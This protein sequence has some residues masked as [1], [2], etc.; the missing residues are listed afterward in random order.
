MGELLSEKTSLT[1]EVLA[2]FEEKGITS[3]SVF[4]FGIEMGNDGS[5]HFPYRDGTK[6][7]QGIP[8]GT[9]SF[10]WE[11]GVPP[12]LFNLRDSLKKNLFLV[13]GETDTMKLRQELGDN[14]DTGVIG[15]PG[16]ETWDD[17]MA[18][19]L[20]QAE[21]I[22]V[23]LD[24][25][26]DYK[27]AGRVD[28][29]WTQIRL[30]LGKRARR[31]HLPNQINDVCEFF[32]TY[33]L[34]DLRTIVDR[35]PSPG[36]SRF[37]VLDLTADPPP[38]RWI[39]EDMICGGD[40]HM[41]IGEPSIGK[42]WITMGMA[43]AVAGNAPTFLQR[44]VLTH[45]RVL[46]IDEESPQDLIYHRLHRLGLNPEIAKN[47]RYLSNE[48]IRL[49]KQ[50]D[51]IVTEALDYDPELI[52]LDSL[53]RFHTEDENN[54]GAMATLFNDALKPLARKTGAAVVLIH[55]ANKT[56]SNSS[57]KRSRGS[58]DITAG[59]DCGYDVR[60]I[61]ERTV[62]VSNYKSRRAAQSDTFFVTIQDVE[63]RVELI[64]GDTQYIPF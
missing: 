45:G 36:E 25:D 49:D 22:W 60:A 21:Q 7:R 48:N 35:V 46:Y 37:T 40:I 17:R 39:I 18:E 53:T 29:A 59:A 28:H 52:I 50:A 33:G 19:D 26:G 5:I 12:C 64:G 62:A 56:D 6:K 14:P 10:R 15:L 13:E 1:P 23:I 11:Q 34:D 38:V 44:D 4:D 8:S 63:D 32:E 24:N 2:W 47:I 31:V 58:G 51:D 43:I 54:A 61:A 27:V 42:S 41:L 55:H 57:Y 30:A 20:T 3:E 9:R 16:I